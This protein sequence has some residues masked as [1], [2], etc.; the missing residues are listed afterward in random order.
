MLRD[1]APFFPGQRRK[2]LQHERVRIAA[3]LGDDKGNR[4]EALLCPVHGLWAA[5]ERKRPNAHLQCDLRLH[6]IRSFPRSGSFVAAVAPAAFFLGARPRFNGST[7]MAKY[8][9][10]VRAAPAGG[11]RWKV[12]AD[13]Q[14]LRDGTAPTEFEA[15]SAADE[16]MKQIQKA[17]HRQA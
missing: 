5:T 16:A 11:Y 4:Q 12:I 13:G 9:T 15:R 1:Q 17:E 3:H 8:S 6:D 2:E 7:K 10:L 14:S